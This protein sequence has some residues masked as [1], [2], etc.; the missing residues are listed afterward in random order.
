MWLDGLYMGGPI[1]AEYGMRYQKPEYLKLVADQ[2]MMML[3]KTR[4]KKT[5]LLYHAWDY[6]KAEPWADKT[7]GCSAEFWGRSIGWVPVAILTDL[8]FIQQEQYGYRELSEAVADLLKAI[9]RYQSKSGMWYQVVNKIGEEGNWPETSCSCLF[10]AALF[11]AVRK[12][13]LPE[14]YLEQAV[15]GMNAV[16]DT[17]VQWND[18][19]LLVENICIGTGVG[20][21]THYCNRPRSTNDLHG[22]GAFLLMCAEAQRAAE[23]GF[24][25]SF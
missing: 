2:V 18:E 20:D 21:Y 23:Q 24:K 16:F 11:K 14:R 7:T 4:D 13:F 9:C 10:A 3:E 8:D 17:A 15:A 19:E 6:R 12:G 5:G 25:I 22:V 1:C